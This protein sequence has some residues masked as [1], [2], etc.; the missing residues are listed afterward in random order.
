M[1]AFLAV[2]FLS[3]V[4]INVLAVEPVDE[5]QIMFYYHIPLGADKQHSKHQFGLRF[6]QTSHDP[7]DVVSINDLESKPAAMDFRMGYDGVQS[8]NIRGV[9]YAKYLIAKAA[10]GEGPAM[11]AVDETAVNGSATEG[12]TVA[13][14][15]PAE[16]DTTQTAEAPKEEKG[17]IQQKLDDLPFGVVIGVILGVGIIAGVG[18]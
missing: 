2:V 1:R 12:E 16:A 7:R 14:D 15:V 5:Q 18:G 4:S 10:E 9:D 17:V 8:I 11:E 13:E 6:D 3:L